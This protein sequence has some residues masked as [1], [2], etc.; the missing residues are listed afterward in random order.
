MRM[1]EM[2]FLGAPAMCEL[3]HCNLDHL[4]GSVVNPRDAAGVE[5]NVIAGYCWHIQVRT[6]YRSNLS[7]SKLKVTRVGTN[8]RKEFIIAGE[9][10]W[11][12][13]TIDRFTGRVLDKQIEV[14]KE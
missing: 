3:I 12:H 1:L 13:V 11:V 9:H 2:N 7:D 5:A 8:G 6:M 4:C 10:Y 14:V